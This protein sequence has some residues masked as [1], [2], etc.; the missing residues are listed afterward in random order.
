M[1]IRILATGLT[2]AVALFCSVP[3]EAA[4]INGSD[5]DN[6]G[7]VSLQTIQGITFTAV[8]GGFKLKTLGSPTAYTGV[9]VTGGATPDEIDIGQSITGNAISP[10]NI[11]SITIGFLFDGPEFGDVNEI[12]QI[13]INGTTKFTL[14]ATGSNTATW[15]GP[16]G[17]S[18]LSPAT[19]DQAAV[20]ML[21]N[22]NL[23]NVTSIGFAP[24]QGNVCPSGACNNQSDF[25]LVQLDT[26]VPEPS[27]LGL[28][29]LG[30]VGLGAM[31]R[32]RSPS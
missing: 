11:G 7:T 31:K 5:F 25:G 1:D 12:A 24:L 16:G 28:I 2:A 23:T 26:S 4:I 30:L 3:T 9:G 6:T 29:G 27:T 21:S 22:L 8:G 19:G 17:V 32:R 14:T 15:T 10:F 18:N 20:W 13:T